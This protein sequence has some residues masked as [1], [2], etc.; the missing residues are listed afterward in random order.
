MSKIYLPS[1]SPE[2]WKQSLADSK[3]QWKSGYPAKSLAYCWQ[4]AKNDFPLCIK[5]VFKD[6]NIPIFQ[7][8]ETIKM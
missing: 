8:V 4:E 7:E 6:F 1:K 2:D 5:N 3:K